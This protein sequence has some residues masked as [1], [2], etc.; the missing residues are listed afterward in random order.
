MTYY[1]AIDDFELTIN[2]IK[3]YDDLSM[4]IFMFVLIICTYNIT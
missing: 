2:N 1:Y 3:S 4:L